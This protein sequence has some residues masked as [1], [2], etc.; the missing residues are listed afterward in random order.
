MSQGIGRMFEQSCPD[1]QQTAD[2]ALLNAM[3]VVLGPQQKSDGRPWLQD[4]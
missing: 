3:H 4:V 2:V 1:G